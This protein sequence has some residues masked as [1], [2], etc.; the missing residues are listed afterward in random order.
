MRKCKNGYTFPFNFDLLS[1]KKM[2][3]FSAFFSSKQIMEKIV[4]FRIE[5]IKASLNGK[6]LFTLNVYKTKDIRSSRAAQK[7]AL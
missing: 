2:K 3:K 7:Y 1:I 6:I 5:I 4:N